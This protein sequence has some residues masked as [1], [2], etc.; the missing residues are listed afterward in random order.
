M[1]H[2]Q[3]RMQQISKEDTPFTRFFLSDVKLILPFYDEAI[4]V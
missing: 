3:Q 2:V 4:S 1:A